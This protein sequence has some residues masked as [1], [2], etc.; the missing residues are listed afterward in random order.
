MIPTEPEPGRRVYLC[1]FEGPSRT[2]VALD[3]GTT[4]HPRAHD[5]SGR[6]LDRRPVRAGGGVGRGREARRAAGSSSSR[7]GSPSSRTGSRRRSRRRS[8]SS[9]RS[10]R[11][12]G[13]PRRRT[14]TRSAQRRAGS[15]WRSA[16]AH[17]S[18]FAESMKA[19]SAGGRRSSSSRWRPAT[20]ASSASLE[21]MEGGFNFPFGGDP[22][23]LM[24]GPA[25]VRRAAG[26]VG[27]RG[28]AR[29]VRD[30][31]AE[32]GG[33]AHRCGARPGEGDGRRGRAGAR[34]PRRDAGPVSRGG[35]ARQ[36]GPPGI[37]ARAPV[38]RS[39]LRV[40]AR[41]ASPR[42]SPRRGGSP[43]AC[44][45]RAGRPA[46]RRPAEA[47]PAPRSAARHGRRLRRSGR[48]A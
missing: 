41:A 35:R 31:D 17:V 7:C 13:S 43:S 47:P 14:S 19:A 44:V 46:R 8:S 23:D 4:A 45:G 25:R 24:R 40:R 11:R 1:A 29:A 27:R 38:A 5:R 20:R 6:G 28:A 21:T 37:H 10:A 3:A 22:E 32:H 42:S 48:A 12:R 16:K 33:R 15:S 9:G 36:R 34:A 39:A 2:W 26:R 18:P 30:A